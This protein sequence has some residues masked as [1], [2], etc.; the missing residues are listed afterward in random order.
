MMYGH[1]VL[2]YVV[3]LEECLETP[4]DGLVSAEVGSDSCSTVIDIDAFDKDSPAVK[5]FVC[6]DD[7]AT[8]EFVCKDVLAVEEFYHTK[9]SGTKGFAC[10]YGYITAR[11]PEQGYQGQ[12]KGSRAHRRNLSTII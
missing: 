6:E 11:R 1:L 7:S 9:D 10:H 4:V 2:Q 12:Q 3:L 5:E 8:R